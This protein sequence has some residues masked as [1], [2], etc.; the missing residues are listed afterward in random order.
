MLKAAR[1]FKDK[2][3]IFIAGV[4]HLP[5]HLYKEVNADEQIIWNNSHQLLFSASAA[6]VKSGTSTL[7][8]ALC[9]VPQIICYKA[10]W[11]SYI[12]AR[13]VVS[14]NIRFI[15]LVNLILNKQVCPELIQH[16]CT[17]SNIET[18]LTKILQNKELML[19][20]YAELNVLLHKTSAS[21]NAAQLI[22]KFIQPSI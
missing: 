12:I 11:F 9:G 4:S 21:M 19:K 22:L 8:A 7:E 17:A 16:K 20:D 2:F 3:T 1:K 14:K 13:L 10:N 6:I 15:S 18:E 5:S